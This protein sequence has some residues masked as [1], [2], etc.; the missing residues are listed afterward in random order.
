MWIGIPIHD[1]EEKIYQW[2]L[3]ENENIQATVY[4]CATCQMKSSEPQGKSKK[5]MAQID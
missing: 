3:T 4:Q 5:N 1:S 2:P